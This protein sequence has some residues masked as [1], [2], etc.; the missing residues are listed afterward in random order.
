MRDSW[1][2]RRPLNLGLC[3]NVIHTP[4]LPDSEAIYLPMLLHFKIIISICSVSQSVQRPKGRNAGAL[5][6]LQRQKPLFPVQTESYIDCTSFLPRSKLM[7]SGTHS[8]HGCCTGED[9][10]RGKAIHSGCLGQLSLS[11]IFQLQ[12]ESNYP[13][14]QSKGRN[15]VLL[16]GVRYGEGIISLSLTL[17]TEISQVLSSS[18]LTMPRARQHRFPTEETDGQ[19]ASAP[20]QSYTGSIQVIVKIFVL[21]ILPKS[22]VRI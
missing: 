5:K 16:G 6:S 3:R 10:L 19:R 17:L 9:N 2:F 14:S 21:Y 18:T 13:F 22:D 1:A 8:P 7:P 11:L 4:R 12:N 15:A 20:I